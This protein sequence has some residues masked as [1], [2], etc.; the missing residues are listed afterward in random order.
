MEA[1]F[2]SFLAISLPI[3][4][5]APVTNAMRRSEAEAREFTGATRVFIMKNSAKNAEN[6]I[7]Q[8]ATLL[9]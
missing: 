7:S 8:D 3:P 5:F 1:S 9:K 2:A 6:F 4:L